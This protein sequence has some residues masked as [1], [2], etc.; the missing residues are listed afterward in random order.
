M[1]VGTGFGLLGTSPL[2]AFEQPNSLSCAVPFPKTPGL[3]KYVARFVVQTQLADIPPD[4]MELGKKSLLDGLGLAL[5]GSKL[6]TADIL[7]RYMQSL[8]FATA[9]IGRAHV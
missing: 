9:E 3:T 7:Q 5:A 1:A 8:G 4:V 6:E 2:E